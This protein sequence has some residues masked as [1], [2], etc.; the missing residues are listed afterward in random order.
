MACFVHAGSA[1][2]SGW[3]CRTMGT[4]RRWA[5]R[6]CRASPACSA[7]HSSSRPRRVRCPAG[8][9]AAA[10]GR[11]LLWRAEHAASVPAK[12]VHHQRVSWPAASCGARRSHLC[13]VAHGM[14][15]HACIR[16]RGHKNARFG[17]RICP[18][19][20]TMR[21]YGRLP[22][23]RRSI[24]LHRPRPGVPFQWVVVITLSCRHGG[25]THTQ[26]NPAP[27]AARVAGRC[28]LVAH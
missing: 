7:L 14:R 1:S 28:A 16:G 5:R 19:P 2:V 24:D 22:I 10:E 6:C 20:S 3:T 15:S 18:C 12:Q 25:R 21:T 17:H 13:S 4:W 27:A 9:Q 11:L 23:R 8:G 26:P